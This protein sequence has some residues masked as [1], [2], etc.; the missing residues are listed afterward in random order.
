MSEIASRQNPRFRLWLELLEARGIKK[1]ERVLISGRKLVAE[2]IA[3]NDAKIEDVLYSPKIELTSP[4]AQ[5]PNQ[6][7]SP[8]LF[9]ELDI[10]GTDS[11][12]LVVKKP[13]IDTWTGGP[14]QGLELIV[15]LSDPGNL[16]ALLRSAE[17]FGARRVILCRE[18]C[19]P[20][21]PKAL[22]S[23]SGAAFRVALAEACSIHDL[24]VTENMF[25]LHMQGENLQRFVWPQS[26]YLVL[27]E[28]GQGLPSQLKLKHVSIPML[29]KI[30]SLN[31]MVS[32]SVAMFSYQSR[33]AKSEPVA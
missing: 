30:E 21:L 29:G 14:P 9:K 2:F 4:L 22:R 11:P 25:G 16:G 18:A 1:Q 28:E 13:N 15:A 12:L 27:G 8:A 19:S 33:Q 26:L 6:Q 31:A 24:P 32:A 17:A 7:L 10:L 20:F 23:A 3:Q 5:F